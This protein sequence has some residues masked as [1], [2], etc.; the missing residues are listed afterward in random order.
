M[1]ERYDPFGRMQSLRQM[2]DQLLEDAFVLPRG[3]G[4]EGR[5]IGGGTALN[6]YEEGE[7][8]IVEAPLAGVKPEDINVSVENGVLTVRAERSKEEDRRER[9][10]MLREYHAGSFT[11][12]IRLPDT[13]DVNACDATFEHGVLRITFPRSEQA[14]PRRIEVRSGSD[15]PQAIGTG[16]HDGSTQRNPSTSAASGTAT[17]SPSAR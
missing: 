3:G 4:P 13:V 8:L 17:S 1:I 5:G 11:R 15:Q 9:N 2:M 6:V 10:Y 7:R 12:S 14:R 16:T